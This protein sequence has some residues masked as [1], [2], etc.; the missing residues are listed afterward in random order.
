SNTPD[1]IT[2]R[3]QNPHGHDSG[4][5][6]YSWNGKDLKLKGE[7]SQ[8]PD[9][10]NFR[11]VLND[12][13]SGNI[14]ASETDDVF[15]GKPYM[16]DNTVLAD[17]IARGHKEALRLI[18]AKNY[19]E[20]VNRLSN[21][22][23]MTAKLVNLSESSSDE[24][25]DLENWLQAWDKMKLSVCDYVPALN[26]YGFVLSLAGNNS[27]AIRVY[28]RVIKQSPERTVAYLNKG[29]SL[30]VMKK[31]PE[32]KLFYRLYFDKM[33]ASNKAALI[34]ERVVKRRN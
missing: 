13:I 9:G 5:Q 8:D 6:E 3:Y 1:R 7:A 19:K 27:E 15:L 12:V 25:E 22:F 16:V 34:P 33:K 26:D 4:T 32:A 24:T 10:E 28:T 29:D 18:R 11:N 20:A 30:W 31:F 2:L 17:T 23:Q 14:T 21:I